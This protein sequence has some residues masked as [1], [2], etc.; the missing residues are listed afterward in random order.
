MLVS[1]LSLYHITFKNSIVNIYKFTQI[2]RIIYRNCTKRAFFQ[3]YFCY[4]PYLSRHF[5]HLINQRKT[6]II[7]FIKTQTVDKVFFIFLKYN[8]LPH[9]PKRGGAKDGGCDVRVAACCFGLPHPCGKLGCNCGN[10]LVAVV[11][12]QRL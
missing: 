9:F 12:G 1:F 2:F 7:T 5:C 4:M 10:V 8:S 11:L 3:R 6:D